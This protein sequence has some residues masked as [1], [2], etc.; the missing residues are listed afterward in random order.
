MK[1]LYVECAMGAAGDMLM[2]ALCELIEDKETFF[3]QL[4]ELFCGSARMEWQPAQKCGIG[5]TSVSVKIGDSAE[6]SL[7]VDM[8]G[9]AASHNHDHDHDHGHEHDHNHNHEHHHDHHQ[10]HHHHHDHDHHHGHE[11]SHHHEHSHA[12]V[13][14]DSIADSLQKLKLS[15]TVKTDALAIYRLIAAAEARAHG[16]A[17]SDVHFHEVGRLDAIVDIVG[18]C[19]LMEMLSPANIVVSPIHVGSGHVRC[20]HGILPVPAPATAHILQ[21]VPT[22]GG[23]IRGELCTPTGAAILKYFAQSFGPMPAMI[24]EKTGYGMGK[25]DFPAANCLRVFWGEGYGQAAPAREEV[26]ELKCN[27][28]DMSAEALAFACEMLLSAG[29]KDVFTVA[30]GMK[31]GRPGT[32]ITLLCDVDRVNEFA[33][34]LFK[35]TSSL[36]VR[37]CVHERYVLQREIKTLDTP[38]GTVRVKISGG[39]GQEKAKIEYEDIAALAKNNNCSFVE[40]EAKLTEECT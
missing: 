29:A 20:S 37:T 2:A 1:T 21:G 4:N 12:P 30:C 10:H 6:E 39:A 34:L 13:N 19:C 22:Y 32:L 9:P 16:T 3:K 25:K 14:L 36:G 7:D 23:Q 24:V 15:E 31:K 8:G 28:D 40:M 18:V 38:Y 11:H 17:V 5:G 27:I 33:Q 26:A 35:Y